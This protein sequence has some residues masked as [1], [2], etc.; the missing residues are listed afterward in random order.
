MKALEKVRDRRYETVSALAMDVQH[1][2]RDE[3]ILARAPSTIYSLRKFL[4]RHRTSAAAILLTSVF[5]LILLAVFL[6]WNYNR[7]LEKEMFLMHRNSFSRALNSLWYGNLDAGLADLEPIR[8]SKYLGSEAR[9]RYDNTLRAIR[10]RVNSYTEKIKTNPEDA[11]NYLIRAQQYYCLH[12]KENMIADML[13]Y[14]NILNPL[15]ETN[16]HDLWFRDFLIGLWRSSPTNLGQPVNSFAH[17]GMGGITPDGLEIIL[18]S[19]RSGW[20]FDIWITKRSTTDHQWGTP[21]KLGDPINTKFWDGVPS[22]SADGMSLYFS[23]NRPSAYTKQG[24]QGPPND[25]WVSTR[26]ALGDPWAAPVMLAEPINSSSDEASS[27]ISA[28]GLEFYISSDRPGGHGK[29]DLWVTKRLAISEP[30]GDPVNLGPTVNSANLDF[31]Q[32]I[33]ADGLILFFTSDRPGGYGGRDIWVTTRKT[34]S[35]NWSTPVNLGPPVNSSQQDQQPFIWTEGSIL[36]FSSNRPSD[37]YGG[38]DIWQVSIAPSSGVFKE[39][40]HE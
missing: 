27:C 21:Q 31:C 25:R 11:E 30:W 32:F 19:D 17:D 39:D 8:D 18:G 22:L 34:K 35:E 29:L 33:W 4:R 23:S 36:Y 14:V 7:L 5:A 20:P 24:G 10:N 13:E 3:P 9:R 16:P 2:L 26:G 37:G 28:D 12:E 15:D 1:H 38:L 40:S 6:V